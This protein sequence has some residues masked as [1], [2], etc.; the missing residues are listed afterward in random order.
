MGT[1]ILFVR[2]YKSHLDVKTGKVVVPPNSSWNG[3]LWLVIISTTKDISWTKEWIPQHN[4]ISNENYLR[5]V[6]VKCKSSNA[7]MLVLTVATNFIQ[8]SSSRR[9]SRAQRPTSLQMVGAGAE[10]CLVLVWALSSWSGVCI[11]HRCYH[12]LLIAEL[13]RVPR[14]SWPAQL[15]RG[16]P[17]HRHWS[18]LCYVMRTAAVGAGYLNKPLLHMVTAVWSCVWLPVPALRCL[19]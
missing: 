3:W 16:T 14:L 2:I 10:N 13:W 11:Y 15:T 19:L 17:D 4:S 9:P 18:P 6:A 5:L 7:N 12:F 1:Q 8:M